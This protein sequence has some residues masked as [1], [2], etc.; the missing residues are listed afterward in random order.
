MRIALALA[1]LLAAPA[2]RANPVDVFG[3]GSRNAALAGAAVA[4]VDDTAATYYNPA[5]LARS[6]DLR[7]DLGYQ[8]GQP[9]LRLNDKPSPI[10]PTHGLAAGL[11]V[12]GRLAGVRFAFGL[13]LFLPD[14][15][16]NRTKSL[17]YAQ[18]RW[19]Y[20]DNRT[21]RLYLAA[22]LA[23]ELVRGLYVGASLAFMAR[24]T[25]TVQLK[26][27]ISVSDPENDTTLVTAVNVDLLSVRYPQF[28]ILWEVNRWLSLGVSYRHSFALQLD[29]G[30]HIAGSVSDPG[31]KPLIDGGTF[32]ARTVS[33]DLFQPWQV[34]AGAAVRLLPRLLLSYDVTFARWS[35][36]QAPASWVE[37]KLDLG[38]AFNALVNVPPPRVFP[39]PGFHD[40][41]IPRV[42]VEWRALDRERVA[43][44]LRAGYRFEPTPAPEQRGET[45]YADGDKHFVALGAGVVLRRLTAV[46][47]RPF[48]IDAHVGLTAIPPRA[49]RKDDPTDKVGDYVGSGVIVE[50]GVASRWAF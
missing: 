3:L 40:I 35:E 18:P 1:L 5:A 47:P 33:A 29:Q 37:V 30:F 28:G 34:T 48:T 11:S 43:L 12:P 27:N 24:T 41:L 19:V 45:N 8:V 25:G 13:S 31:Q 6:A 4:A 15:R 17:A 10:D 42:G 50:G 21:Q 26:G 46:L 2:A 7:I 16:L 36:F 39:S 22:G 49:N 44:D 38:A 23:V 20:Y 14:D 32:E 9:L